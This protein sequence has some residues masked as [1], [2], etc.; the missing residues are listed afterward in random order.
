MMNQ[1][2]NLEDS[3]FEFVYGRGTFLTPLTNALV[4]R[5]IKMSSSTIMSDF[6]APS[7]TEMLQSGSHRFQ[8][9]TKHINKIMIPS[10]WPVEVTESSLLK[11]F[12]LLGN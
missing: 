4:R 7:I 11:L 9:S 8:I 10:W 12:I 1:N 5:N 6:L 2:Q 3:E